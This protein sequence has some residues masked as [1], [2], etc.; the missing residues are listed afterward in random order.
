[1]LLATRAT[2]RRKFNALEK[3]L[4]TGAR[5]DPRARL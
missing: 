5:T 4:R 1:L 3:R 2:L